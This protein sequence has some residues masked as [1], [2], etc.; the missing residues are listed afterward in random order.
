MILPSAIL[1]PQEQTLSRKATSNKLIHWNGPQGQEL[2]IF[3]QVLKK[4]KQTP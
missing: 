1:G 2:A 4:E 3:V